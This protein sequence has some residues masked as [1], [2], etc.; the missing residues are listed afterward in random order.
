MKKFAG[1]LLLT[2]AVILTAGCIS[3]AD[4]IVGSWQLTAPI[5][6]DNY[7]HSY[8]ITFADDGTGELI[9]SYSDEV[10]DYVFP[11]LWEKNG[12]TYQY[13]EFLIFTFSEDGRTFTDYGQYTYTLKP[14]EE[15]FGSVWTEVIPEGADVSQYYSYVFNEDGTGVETIY[16]SGEEVDAGPF[17]WKDIGDNRVLIR[18]LYTYSFTEDGKMTTG[19]STEGVFEYQDG[20]WVETSQVG[21]EVTTYAFSDDGICVRSIYDGETN[22]LIV[23]YVCY[24][25][26][27]LT[28]GG[29]TVPAPFITPLVPLFNLPV[30]GI[31]ELA[32]LYDLEFLDENTLQDIEYGD[33]LK[34]VSPA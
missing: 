18:Y 15:K 34:R 30:G 6:Y 10:N 32:Y 8:Q 31:L 5:Q 25:T 33:I 1:I 17:T 26:P 28:S 23:S 9:S 21:D 22:N 2:A 19:F 12:D 16:E 3:P 27:V 24:Y 29:K 11:I 7:A 20:I 4:P 13:E 14:G